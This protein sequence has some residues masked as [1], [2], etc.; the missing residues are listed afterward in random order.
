MK[1]PAT[2]KRDF[3]KPCHTLGHCPYGALVE[4][5][6]LRGVRCGFETDPIESKGIA[7]EI[8]GHDC[9]IFY[10]GEQKSE[11]KE[12]PPLTHKEENDYI[13]N[14]SAWIGRGAFTVWVR[15]RDNGQ[16]VP[17]VIVEIFKTGDE[18]GEVVD[19]ASAM[20]T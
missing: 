1:E 6:P 12:P 18:D 14:S 20:E 11:R 5:F 19:S 2:K 4:R 9:P 10:V 17:G 7:C 16:P 15:T 13:L 3:M 8:F